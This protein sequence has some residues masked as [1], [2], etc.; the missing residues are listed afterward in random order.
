MKNEIPIVRERIQTVWIINIYDFM[1]QK[2]QHQ[3][4]TFH[5]NK[6]K[7][8]Q[9]QSPHQWHYSPMAIHKESYKWDLQF[10]NNQNINLKIILKKI[11]IFKLVW[12]NIDQ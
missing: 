9:L 11:N 1:M 5:P 3:W 2:S 12:F 6:E 10:H 8:I 4:Y 7:H